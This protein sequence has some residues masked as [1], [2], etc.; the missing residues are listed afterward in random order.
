MGTRRAQTGLS[1]VWRNLGLA[2]FNVRRDA[3]KARAAYD[4]A[5]RARIRKTPAC[6]TNATSFGS[7]LAKHPRNVCVNWNVILTLFA[8]T[9]S[10]SKSAR[11]TIKPRAVTP[12]H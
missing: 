8:A 2:C 12:T 9:T 4:R 3:D 10:R 1:V 11:S 5:F 7:A 6:S